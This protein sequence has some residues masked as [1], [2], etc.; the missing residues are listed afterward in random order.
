[1]PDD[2][3]ALIV[4]ASRGLG[5]GLVKELRSRGWSV[6]GTVRNESG[7]QRVEA[8][9]G[10]AERLDTSDAGSVAALSQRLASETF[11]LVFVNAGIKGAEHQDPGKAASAE[12]AELFQINSVAPVG[13]AREFL[14]RVR[15][16]TGVIAFMSSDL[17]SVARTDDAYIPLYRASKAALNSLIRSF[18]A[19]LGGRRVTVLAIHPGWVRTDMGGSSAPIG[20]EESVRGVV[21]DRGARRD[22]PPRVCRLPGRRTR[23]VSA[24]VGD[25][26]DRAVA[27][28][29]DEEAAVRRDRDADRP[30]PHAAILGDEPGQEILIGAGARHDAHDLVPG[31]LTPVP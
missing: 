12:I 24:A 30:A 11:D 29:A 23:L 9:G 8:L 2:R 7:A 6:V 20:I 25:A 17:G 15:E 14:G 19:G 26:P 21:D 10:K 3:T 1:M 18:A 13:I 31:A 28:L 22:R 16:G 4:G 5:L 27:V